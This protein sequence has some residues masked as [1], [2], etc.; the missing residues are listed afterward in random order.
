MPYY[1]KFDE[2]G[3]YTGIQTNIPEDMTDWYEVSEELFVATERKRFRL[4]SGVVRAET[5]EEF[6]AY[7]QALKLSSEAN[8][9]RQ[10]RNFLLEESDK[11]LLADRWSQFSS[12]QQ[13]KITAYRQLLRDITQQPGFPLEVTWPTLDLNGTANT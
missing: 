11:Y 4:D 7:M 9:V 10:D 6:D 1:T 3:I 5:E 2:A 12:T 13:Q 8:K